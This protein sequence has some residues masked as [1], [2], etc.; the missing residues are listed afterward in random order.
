MKRYTHFQPSD[1][2]KISALAALSLSS[3]AIAAELKR[4]PA[5]IRRERARCGKRPV[6]TVLT[7]RRD[8]CYAASA[9]C[10]VVF[11]VVGGKS[12]ATFHGRS[13]A[14]LLMR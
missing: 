14:I 9:E 12:A 6:C 13:S 8:S 11:T 4:H 5:T 2:C 3:A 7:K 1:L 10:S